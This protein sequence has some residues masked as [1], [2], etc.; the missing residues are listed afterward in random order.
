MTKKIARDLA[1]VTEELTAP[2]VVEMTE[3]E[4]SRV[5]GGVFLAEEMLDGK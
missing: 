5:A 3:G 2:A 4:I 1:S